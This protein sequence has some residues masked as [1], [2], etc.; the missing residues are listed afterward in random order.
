MIETGINFD[1]IHSFY[2]LNLILSSVRISPAEPKTTLIDKS[3]GDGSLDLSEAH[4][5]I[6]FYD[7]E[8]SFVFTV[9]PADEMTFDEK[10]S[11]VSGLLNGRKC[12]NI[13]LDRD[14]DYY[15]FGRIRVD[16]Y[17]QDKHLK[18]IIIGATVYPY[19]HKQDITVFTAALTEAEKTITLKNGR[20]SVVPEITC[21][22][23]NTTVIFG[24]G[25]YT[26]NAGTHKILDIRLTMGNNVM[27]VSGS[28]TITITYQEGEL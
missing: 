19:K 12:K 11:Q 27:K 5:E 9:S 10:V 8:C 17:L 18:Q 22:D 23:S 24:G 16:D 28:G 4:G 7:R 21:T 2:D 6:K 26:L 1:G 3:G 15:Y 20:K 25:T 13:T 14:S